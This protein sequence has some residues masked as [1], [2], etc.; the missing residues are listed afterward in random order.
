MSIH[1]CWVY[2]CIL[3]LIGVIKMWKLQ[4]SGFMIYVVA[5]VAAMVMGIVY[6]GV[7][8]S[9]M[10]IVFSVLFVVLYGLNLKHLK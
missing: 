7:T 6:S 4:K 1:N 5:T 10:G 8:A 2:Y 9:M 3:S